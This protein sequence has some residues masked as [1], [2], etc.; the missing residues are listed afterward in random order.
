MPEECFFGIDTSCYTTSIAK[1]ADYEVI[2]DERIMLSVPQGSKGLRQSEAVFAHLKN[3]QKLFLDYKTT[4]IEA[5]GYSQKPCDREMSYMPVFVVG[6]SFAVSWAKMLGIPAIALT[7]QHGH[8]YSAFLGR[9]IENGEYCA[10][11]IS[12]GTLDVLEVNIEGSI[13][14]IKKIGG[15][16][17]LTCGQL[18]DRV[19][20]KAGL[21]FPAGRHIE[22][23]YKDGGTKFAVT[24]NGLEANLSGAET[25]ALRALEAGEDSARVLSGVIDTAAETISKLIKNAAGY[26]RFIFTGGVMSNSVIRKTAEQTCFEAGAEC[27]IA[28]KKYCSDN[29]V[30]IAYGAQI[31]YNEGAVK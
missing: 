8:I 15:T 1:V 7:H 26:K 10:F 3:I 25:Q 6:E 12:G 17:D 21:S 11:H 22:E 19:G 31:L 5:I 30:G 23:L 14:S 18:I 24:V 29:A 28:E 20:V 2:D 16:L 13:K 9:K 27:I 4:G